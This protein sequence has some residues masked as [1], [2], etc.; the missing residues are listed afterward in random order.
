MFLLFSSDE[1]IFESLKNLIDKVNEYV[2]SK[3]YAVMLLRTKNFKLGV[4]R[5]AWIICDRDDRL[6][7][8]REEERRH[9]TNRCIE[10]FFSLIKKRM[11]DSD[12]NSWSFKM[13]NDQHNHEATFVDS[14]SAQRKIA[15]IKKIRDDIS[16]QLQIQTKSALRFS[17]V[18]A[19]Q[20]ASLLQI[21]RISKIQSSLRCLNLEIFTIW[22]R[23]F[24]E[25][26]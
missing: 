25:N 4:K 22:K 10:C 1:Q 2:V 7:N 16:R 3:D 6:R 5:K 12:D 26:H 20:I 14:H 17:R 18:F 11:N 21:S 9:I 23:N 19:F 8:A 13:I 15:L 24:V